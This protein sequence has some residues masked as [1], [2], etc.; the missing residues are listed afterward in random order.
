VGLERLP[1]LVSSVAAIGEYMAQPVEAKTHRF[2]HIDRAIA[3][4]NIGGVD[5]NEDQKAAGVGIDMA[6]SPSDFLA[7]VIA[8]NPTTVGG[9]DAS[10]ISVAPCA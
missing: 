2:E 3:V 1:E 8:P 9:F 4:L 5:E 10:V 6:L 7:R